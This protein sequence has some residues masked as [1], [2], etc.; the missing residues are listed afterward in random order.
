[1]AETSRQ[2]RQASAAQVLPGGSNPRS[3]RE[4]VLDTSE[5]GAPAATPGIVQGRARWLALA[6]LVL[7]A[8]VLAEGLTGS[9][10]IPTLLN[11]LTFLFVAG[12]YGACALLIREAS[13]RWGNR[14]AGVLLL[15]AAFGVESEG[16]GAKTLIDPTG[17]VAGASQI[18]SYWMGVNWVPFVD[19]TLFHAVFS[20]AVPILLVELL[21]PRTRGKRLVGSAGLAIALPIFALD[22]LFLIFVA[23]PHYFPPLPLL[24]ITGVGA[25][26]V[27]AAYL[28][29]K[30]LIVSTCAHPDRSERFFVG[31][32]VGFFAGFFLLSD[33]GPR[34]PAAATASLFVG[35]AAACLLLWIRHVGLARNEVAKVDLMLGLMIVIVPMDVVLEIGGDVGVLVLTAFVVGLLLYLRR[36]WARRHAGD[37]AK[38]S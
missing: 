25:A 9:T 36:S 22:S 32:G 34:M 17:S 27:V 19:L 18:Y 33:F 16:L 29:P 15:G 38:E 12:N 8:T 2:V 28:V 10:P 7:L 23:G 20:M 1:M 11:P 14:W 26:Y 30:D 31:L 4:T 5:Q 3:P 13:V 24:F 37:T 35:L 6:A 21:F